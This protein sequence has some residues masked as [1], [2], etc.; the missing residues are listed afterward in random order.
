VDIATAKGGATDAVVSAP[1]FVGREHELAAVVGALG[2]P[3][4][5]VLIE[6]E[7]GVGKSRLVRECLG[8]PELRERRVLVAACPPLLEPFPLGAVVDGLRRLRERVDDL[9]LSPLAGA[10]RPL[11]PEW[12]RDLPPALEPLEDR[13][14]VRHRLL[15]AIV[16]LVE[17]LGVEVLLVEDAHWAD[18]ATLELLLM[19]CASGARG[20]SVVVTYRPMDV[21]AGSLLLRLASHPPEGLRQVRVELAP[22][23]LDEVG[24]LVASMFAGTEVS[25]EFAEFLRERTA[26]IPLALEECLLWL[27]ERRDI[28]RRGGVWVR[29]A[30]EDMRVPPTVR[31]SVLERVE[32]LSPSARRVLEAAAVL[33]EPAEEGLLTA[34]A[35][36]DERAAGRG[37]AGALASALLSEEGPGR[38]VV[39]HV[40]AAKA[41]EEA[42]PVSERRRLHRRAAQAL[43]AS[44]HPLV[45]RLARHYRE[46]ND[47]VAWSHYAEASADLALASGDDRAAVTVLLE[48]LAKVDYPAGERARVARKLGEAAEF[49]A[50]ALGAALYRRVVEALRDALADRG[51]PKAERGEIRLLL[52]AGL[53]ELMQERAAFVEFE[54]AFADLGARPGKAIRAATLLAYPLIPERP[55]AWHL[56]WL[57]RAR[58]LLPRLEDDA[59][60]LRFAKNRTTAL[61]LLGEEDG[62]RAAAQIPPPG[63][64]QREQRIAVD[65]SINLAQAAIDWGRYADA[66]ERLTAAVDQMHATGL[67]RLLPTVRVAGGYLDWYSGDW[68]AAGETAA[69]IADSDASLIMDRLQARQLLGLLN[70][71][72]GAR[73]AAEKGLRAVWDEFTRLGA[74]EPTA[75]IAPA[76][77]G[78]LYLTDGAVDAALAATGPAMEMIVRKSVWLWATDIAAAHADAL[79]AAGRIDELDELVDRF[80][81]WLQ[82]R[83]A[84]AAF[85]ALS[86]CRAILAGGKGD[87]RHAAASF[88]EAAAAW[89]ALPRP[90]DELLALERQGRCL[91]AAGDEQKQK[92]LAVLSQAQQRLTRLGARWD[93]DRVAQLLRQH[94]VEVARPWHGGR[95]GY[96]DR[97]SPRELE[98]VRLVA[99]GLTNP[100]A[101]ET[102]FL[103]PRT[104][105]RHVSAAM[106]KLGVSSRTALAVAATEA[107]LLSHDL[108]EPAS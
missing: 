56:H 4:A 21:P 90:Y 5:L 59:D 29:R 2:D 12:A 38:F 108:E 39:R 66:R 41:V 64:S 14:A 30:L 82:N 31:D 69:A 107:G 6:G 1:A 54:A 52:A 37:L 18:A 83:D 55:A 23:D 20:L 49:G 101:A 84:P 62:W 25:A 43:Q 33:G 81:T 72:S 102:L 26:G 27:R 89:G 15:R 77:L 58:E 47:T 71:A 76:A 32:R 11:F 65:G 35:G 40:L 61:L 80:A 46:A 97:L 28:V 57:E 99:R 93:A 74:V 10:L 53:H 22:L 9:E 45:V 3:P 13:E 95:R 67:Y 19:L 103:S 75:I 17:R 92:G 85:A 48:V 73:G 100:Q 50:T 96:G 7:P 91:L 36:L 105:D 104:V 44:A 94:G 88:A 106:H 79:S 34:V 98:V 8:S 51:V 70:L 68:T 78:R 63:P 86:T 60:R 87:P 16:E 24:R 42:I